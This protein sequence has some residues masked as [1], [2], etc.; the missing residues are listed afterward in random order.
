MVMIAPN[1]EPE[2]VITPTMRLCLLALAR[3][4]AKATEAAGGWRIQCGGETG[5]MHWY[6]ARAVTPLV[7]CGLIDGGTGRLTTAGRRAANK[8]K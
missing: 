8:V 7:E 4:Y 6:P 3:P 1:T 2:I 5:F